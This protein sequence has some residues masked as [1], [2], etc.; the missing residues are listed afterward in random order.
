MSNMNKS[1]TAVKRWGLAVL[2]AFLVG[3]VKGNVPLEDIVLNQAYAEKKVSGYNSM[4]DGLHY[5]RLEMGGRKIVQYA[6]KTGEKVKEIFSSDMAMYQGPE[7]IQNY[8][9]SPDE[10][11]ILF[12]TNEQKVYRHSFK[13][14]YYVF[15]VLRRTVAPLSDKP[16]E[17]AAG[18]SP[19]SYAVAYVY[20]NNLYIKNLRFDTEYQVTDDGV[21][22]EVINGIPDW[23]Y[24]EE[25]VAS[26]SD[27]QKAWEWS[28]DSRFLA[29]VRSDE[30]AV[31]SFSFPVYKGRRPEHPANELY[32]STF[33]FKYPK[34][35]EQN[36][37]IQVR[38][39]DSETKR[40]KTMEIAEEGED[41]YVPRILWTATADRLCVVKLNRRQDKLELLGVNPKSTVSSLMFKEEEEKYIS[42]FV[43]EKLKFLPDN[44]FAL[45]SEKDGYAHLYQYG[46]SGKL[47]RQVTNGEWDVTD[48]YGY[49]T[50]RKTFLVQAAK[51]SPLQREIYAVDAKGRMVELS[52]KP[53]WNQA[54]FSDSFTY[55]LLEWKNLNTPQEVTVC[56][57]KGQ[58]VLSL[59][60]NAA[61]RAKLIEDGVQP[62][63]MFTF[64]T[65][66]GVQLNGWMLKPSTLEEGK[67]YPLLLTQYG[68]P[69][70][71]KVVEKYG[72]SWEQ[73]LAEKG[74]VVACVDGRGTGGR[75]EAFRKCTYMQLGKLEVNDQ[76]EAA[77]YLG[78]LPFIDAEKIGIYGWSYGG[79]VSALAL[80]QTSGVF[81]A[82]VSVAPVTHYKF[83]DTV[84]TERY[85]RKYSENPKGY[86]ENSPLMLAG[87]LSGRLLLMHGT[88]DDNVHFQNTLEYAEA[89]VQANKQFDMH[90]YTNRDHHIRGGQTRL[91][92]NTK[93]IHW[94]DTYLK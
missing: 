33:T 53:G 63:E 19:D 41:F 21:K 13:A 54:Q 78:S 86:D 49:D 27:F 18:F 32:P 5:T 84:Y 36:S 87:N 68:G 57:D 20:E 44:T 91:H 15:D 14:K 9:F 74:Y 39:Y 48:F 17:M 60:D 11:K 73:A 45:L 59:E 3:S 26:G 47:I 77:K 29:F 16:Y 81:K 2:M 46:Q 94:L 83:Y 51:K 10:K 1:L 80:S 69:N 62:K 31:K 30:S 92:L 12:I 66:D 22:N 65:S 4:N 56:D 88:A 75:G 28:P 40:T 52:K 7:T 50:R 8:F 24:E 55:F 42:E 25:F 64:T 23:V 89:L 35:G 70:N 82:A 58:P 79:F 6:Y 71:Q 67:T 43:Y 76:A 34:V 37:R 61:L 90:V 38:V 93:I 72:I 85:M